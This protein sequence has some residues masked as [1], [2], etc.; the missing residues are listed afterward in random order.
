MVIAVF[1][2]NGR[3]GKQTVNAAT[4]RRHCVYGIDK[5]GIRA[6]N[7]PNGGKNIDDGTE[8]PD[9][10]FI[11]TAAD[12]ADVKIDAVIDFSAAQATDDVCDFCLQHRCALVSGVTGRTDEQNEKIRRL[13]EI[14]P[15]V[16]SANFSSG[17]RALNEICK[18]LA[19][20][21]PDWDC[22][23]V[24]IHRRGKVD[25]PSGTAKMLAATLAQRK[26]F[27]QTTIHS[28]RLGSN[29]GC[30]SIMLASEGESITITHQAENTAVFAL[31]A[32]KGAEQLVARLAIPQNG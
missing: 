29:F 3:V 4:A 21:L 15:V 13:S 5:D 23:I 14:L 27:A 7:C 32:V 18:Q 19:D 22:E 9:K 10:T 16:C 20:L 17:I 1:G 11:Y 31:G 24:E 25:S 30:H 2:A 26:S 28:L 12:I 8:Q 6:Y